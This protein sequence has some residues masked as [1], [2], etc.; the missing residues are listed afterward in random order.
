MGVFDSIKGKVKKTIQ[1]TRENI[2]QNRDLKQSKRRALELFTMT[3]LKKLCE[4]EGIGHPPLYSTDLLTGERRKNKMDKRE[5]VNHIVRKSS[6][7]FIVEFANHNRIKVPEEA[8][9]PLRTPELG[10]NASPNPEVKKEDTGTQEQLVS[11]NDTGFDHIVNFIKTKYQQIIR[12]QFFENENQFNDNLI[13]SLR[14]VF[15]GV[16]RIEN[17]RQKRDCSGDILIDGRYVFELKYADNKSTLS[18]GLEEILR[19]KG[20]F[21]KICMVMLD[22]G[23]AQGIVQE[24]EGF[25]KHQGA[26]SVIILQGRGER[27]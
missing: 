16:H 4:E 24:Y 11:T 13:S 8:L 6:L 22:V 26:D 21:E 25:Y 3:Q 10:Q 23:R 27:R 15:G 2:Q 14:S 5:Y 7:E 1:N 17:R 20:R 19:Y 9:Y 18:N 12:D